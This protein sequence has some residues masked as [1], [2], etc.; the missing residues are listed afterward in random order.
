MKPTGMKDSWYNKL[1]PL[2]ELPILK[3]KQKKLLTMNFCPDMNKIFKAYSYFEFDDLKCVILG[4]SPYQTVLNGVKRATGLAFGVPSQEYDTPSLMQIRDA[5]CQDT[6]IINVEDTFDW[7]LESWAKQGVLLINAALTVP[8]NAVDVKSHLEGWEW[9]TEGVIKIINENC[10]ALPF[11][12]MG[13]EAQSFERH[14][15][16]NKN[17]VIKCYHPAAYSRNANYAMYKQGIFNQVNTI[18]E[19]TNGVDFKIKW[20]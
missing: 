14:I 18:I 12:L 7:T 17:H 9:W 3:E 15:D 13:T 4:L 20:L 19:N 2:L 11:V 8:L 6:G 1:K 10:N 16:V 5:L